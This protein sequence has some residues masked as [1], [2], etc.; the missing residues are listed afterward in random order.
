NLVITAV[1]WH[2]LEAASE[3]QRT[4]LIYTARSVAAAVDA[5]LGEYSA[6][7]RMLARSP[8]LLDDGLG[9]FD[10]EARRAFDSPDAWILV[11]D[12]E[13]QQLV[14]TRQQPGQH[15]SVRNPI[16]F[17]AQKRAFETH[18]T[19]ITPIRVGMSS[20]RWITTIEVPIFKN[21][22]AFRALSVSVD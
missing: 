7:V 22:Q 13:G 5:K 12:I 3:A 20:R 1:I 9:A 17:A 11:S 18:A 16:G 2:L 10:A 6:L 8:A 21:G 4:S 14:N 19:V 15:L